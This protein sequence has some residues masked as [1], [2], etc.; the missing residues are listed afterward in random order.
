MHSAFNRAA[1]ALLICAAACA[2]A[3]AR[4][5][6]QVKVFIDRPLEL[7][8][9]AAL[10]PDIIG[11][12]AGYLELVTHPDELEVIQSLGFRTEIVHENLVGFYRSRLDVTRD[13]G[14]YKTLDEI[15]ASL[16][17]LSANHPDITSPKI[18][19]GHSVEGRDIWAVKISDNP[20]VD[21]Q[22]PEVLYTAAIHAREVITPEVLF[23]FMDYLTDNYG[24]DSEV[25]DLV[26][27]REL[28]LV[29]MINPDGYL[30]NQVIAPGGGGMWR[31]NRRAIGATVFGVDLNRNFGYRWGHDNI[32]SSSFPPDEIYRGPAPFSEPETQALRDFI[33]AREFVITIFYHSFSNL[34][35]YPWDYDYL[36]TPDEDIFAAIGDSVEAMNGYAHGHSWSLLYL[37]NGISDDWIYGEQSTKVKSLALTPEVGSQQDGF[38]PSLHRVP[39]LCSQNLRPN[40]FYARIAG[41]LL[42]LRP[43]SRPT[44]AVASYIDSVPYTVSWSDQ[45]T[46]NP[47][48]C[49]ELVEAQ[50]YH[51]ET[52]ALSDSTHWVVDGF[53][54][55]GD[56]FYSP[57]ASFYVATDTVRRPVAGQL[58]SRERIRVGP[59][60][61]LRFRANYELG[62]YADFAYVEVSSDGS[63]FTPLAG[64]ITTDSCI[65]GFG[66]LGHGITG[67]SGGWV[68]GRFDLSAFV[69]QEI[70][71]R[72]SAQIDNWVT[73]GFFYVDD[74]HPVDWFRLHDTISSFLSDTSFTVSEK[75]YG[76]YY[77][78][79]R[80]KDSQDQWGPFSWT[81]ST[82]VAY[83]CT[84]DSDSDGYGDP[85]HP[86]NTCRPDN[87]PSVSNVDQLDSDSDGLG[88]ACDNCPDTANRD[89]ADT[90]QDGI[91]DACCCIGRG[92]A[93]GILG[94]GGPNIADL[95]FLVDYLFQG[96]AAPSC[97]EE[98]NVDGTVGAGG[99]IDVAD[100]SYLVVYLFEA[101]PAPPPCP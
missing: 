54:V 2:H 41:D 75:W 85:G 51:R 25:T 9:L 16:D 46:A 79:V 8:G 3:A 49:Y 36:Q 72:I 35:L 30:Y 64:N 92:N 60:D 43:P 96:G 84:A 70:Q 39:F 76:T 18:C 48:V 99:P 27:N 45:D 44:L 28:W 86:E 4:T 58:L 26:D 13:M 47:A 67:V 52:D 98:G 37:C 62:P 59:G 77:Y 38:W 87:C 65:I 95:T 15:N 19:L 89:Q 29:P 93:D 90:N 78:R 56:Q 1:L 74:I 17:S 66:F 101:G 40:L 5:Y 55:T 94:P 91:G 12:G 22:E 53:T 33:S 23:Y 24:L 31:K 10:H 20:T 83:M 61:T 69:G 73:G 57:P 7:S 97:P 34:L 21:E 6:M 71:V 32:G 68:E 100:L 82:D 63:V 88:D 50:D 80:A 42:A 81:A 14:G 11:N